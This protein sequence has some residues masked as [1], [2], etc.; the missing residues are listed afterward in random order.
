MSVGDNSRV[1][2]HVSTTDY[3]HQRVDDIVSEILQHAVGVMW[4]IALSE[5]HLSAR[6]G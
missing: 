5:V 2:W 6:Y 3:I 4:A 1:G